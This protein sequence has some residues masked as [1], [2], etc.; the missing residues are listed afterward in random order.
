VKKDSSNF[1]SCNRKNVYLLRHQILL[2]ANSVAVQQKHLQKQTSR[3]RK[4]LEKGVSIERWSKVFVASSAFHVICRF[5]MLKRARKT[6]VI[7]FEVDT[8]RGW[9]LFNCKVTILFSAMNC[10]G[11]TFKS[12]T[13]KKELVYVPNREK[14][15]IL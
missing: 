7:S 4:K 1:E 11:I 14:H 13:T 9:I 8:C 5:G 12:I 2:L 15:S 10:C 3:R 6:H